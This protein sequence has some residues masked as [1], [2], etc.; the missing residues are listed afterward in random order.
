V[1]VSGAISSART[2]LAETRLNDSELELPLAGG[3]V[4]PLKGD[5]GL[6]ELLVV[7]VEDPRGRVPCVCKWEFVLTDVTMSVTRER[8]TVKNQNDG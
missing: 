3:D 8:S 2:V 7:A 4:I 6:I 5:C 1:A